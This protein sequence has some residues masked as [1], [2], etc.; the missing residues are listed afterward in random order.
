MTPAPLLTVLQVAERLQVSHDTVVREIKRGAL[1]AVQ[2]GA[3]YRIDPA[4]LAAYLQAARTDS[5]VALRRRPSR[6]RSTQER[7][8]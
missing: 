6:R 4:D 3:R 1:G 2:I 5:P 8:S 7:I